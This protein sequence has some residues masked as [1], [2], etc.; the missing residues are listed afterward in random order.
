MAARSA[1]G[2]REFPREVTREA[3][4]P[5]V[6][7]AAMVVLIEPS[8]VPTGRATERLM[9]NVK[10]GGLLPAHTFAV[11]DIGVAIRVFLRPGVE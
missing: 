6:D 2:Q 5:L 3:D 11:A 7:T 8:E 10:A 9:A 1:A 4:L